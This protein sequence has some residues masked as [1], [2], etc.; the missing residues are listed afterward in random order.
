[1]NTD[2]IT[3]GDELLIGQ[4]V[5]TNSAWMAQ[6]LNF[7]GFNV[8]QITSISDNK[9]HIVNTL[10]E[11]SKYSRL[12]LITGGLGPTNDDITKKTLAEYFGTRLI[13]NES[14]ARHIET[15]LKGRGVGMNSLNYGQADVPENCDLIFNDCGTASGMWFEKEGI[16]YVSM[17]GVPFEMKSMMTR[18]VLPRIRKHFKTPHIIHKTIMTQGLAESHLAQRIAPWEKQLPSNIKLAYLPV[19]GMVRLRMSGS[20]TDES[21]LQKEID[22]QVEELQKYIADFIFGYDDETFPEVLGDLLRTGKK[23]V[24]V[25]E[26]CTGGNI[27]HLITL[28]PGSSDYFTGSITAYSNQIKTS[29]LNV[30]AKDL[31]AYGAVSQPVVEQMAE[32]VRRLFKTDYAIAT[33]GIAGPTGGSAEKPVGTVWIAVCSAQKTVARKFDFGEDRQRTID[34]ASVM[35]MSMLRR[36]ILDMEIS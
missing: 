14:L 18:E 29:V 12:V 17:P 25:A 21:R 20:D 16:V 2:I 8:R 22:H 19:P 27:A 26:S 15:L 10:N 6:Q 1:M 7:L 31:Q 5:D 3:I 28:I 34:K 23:N 11:V 35:S 4:V 30:S 36:L 32:G 9:E 24:A 33:S 13:R